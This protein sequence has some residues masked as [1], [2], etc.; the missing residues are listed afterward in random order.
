MNTSMP[1]ANWLLEEKGALSESNIIFTYIFIPQ[2]CIEWGKEL[3]VFPLN[4]SDVKVTETLN[5]MKDRQ[6][7]RVRLP[8]Q[9]KSELNLF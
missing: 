7:A 6:A 4:T 8:L 1:I 5:S 3:T 9:P 2:N